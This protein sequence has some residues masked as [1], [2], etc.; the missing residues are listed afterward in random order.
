MYA[1]FIALF[2]LFA[3]LTIY[4][5]DRVS[6]AN[7]IFR[8]E[9]NTNNRQSSAAMNMRVAIRERAILLWRMALEQDFFD[10]DALHQEFL[11]FGE[12]FLKERL[13]YEATAMNSEE[14][15]LLV[16]LNHETSMRAPAL[17][18]FGD[19]LMEDDGYVPSLAALSLIV[20]DQ[21]VV[22][23]VLN[24]IAQYQD[25]QNE[26]ARVRTRDAIGR[27]F[28]EL[29]AGMVFS[30][31]CG[32]AFAVFVVRSANRQIV[33]LKNTGDALSEKTQQ[34]SLANQSL[35]QQARHD[36]L[37]GLPNRLFLMEHL[38]HTLALARRQKATGAVLFVDLDGF[39]AIN[40]RF[41]HDVGD[42]TLIAA[43]AGIRGELRES[44]LVTRLGGD[45]FVVVLYRLTERDD[46]LVV[47]HKL[48]SALSRTQGIS[49]QEIRLSA[50]IGICFFPHQND[51][52]ETLLKQADSAMYAA[53][54]AGKNNSVVYHEGH[55]A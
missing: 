52:P 27:I 41:G 3:S 35:T 54:Q 2:I 49:G 19:A 22:T 13:R 15:L 53:K 23:D 39:K 14:Q 30:V 4:A 37:T 29:I 47:S 46:A 51:L 40:D 45:E 43:S 48:L 8:T 32:V 28:Y 33:Q 36:P 50:S 6:V 20:A 21:R 31:L 12:V 10:R 16:S 1:G 34:L 18:R 42:D 24:E 44:D 11:G 17:R 5:F 55:S 9:V 25:I 7:E 38:K 26:N